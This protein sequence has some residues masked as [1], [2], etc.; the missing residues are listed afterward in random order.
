MTNIIKFPKFNSNEYKVR[1][2]IGNL[3]IR[4]GDIIVR[5]NRNNLK[6]LEKRLE[7]GEK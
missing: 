1:Q 4:S 7:D 5:Q 3:L 2:K 6:M